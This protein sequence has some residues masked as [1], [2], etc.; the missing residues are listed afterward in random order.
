MAGD[1]AM[2]ADVVPS[3]PSIRIPSGISM[4]DVD[5]PPSVM[6]G[7]SA[8]T[9]IPS[10]V[11]RA[12]HAR[13]SPT[14]AFHE[15]VMGSTFAPASGLSA[16][17][18]SSPPPVRERS[19]SGRRAPR[20][21]LGYGQPAPRPYALQPDVRQRH[22]LGGVAFTV[23]AKDEKRKS[24]IAREAKEEEEANATANK[25][26]INRDAEFHTTN[27]LGVDEKT[28]LPVKS[29]ICGACQMAIFAEGPGATGAVA[30]SNGQY[31][32]P[33]CF[34]CQLC[35]GEIKG[36]HCVPIG[37]HIYHPGACTEKV[38][39]R[40]CRACGG[41]ILPGEEIREGHAPDVFH[42]RCFKCAC[43]T[44]P[45]SSEV[46][47]ETGADFKVWHPKLEKFEDLQGPHGYMCVRCEERDHTFFMKFLRPGRVDEEDELRTEFGEREQPR[48]CDLTKKLPPLEE[49][50]HADATHR[51]KP[52]LHVNK[53]FDIRVDPA[54]VTCLHCNDSL[55]SLQ[56]SEPAQ[57]AR[58]HRNILRH[59]DEC[60]KILHHAWV[61]LRCQ[62]VME[63]DAQEQ[64]EAAAQER[65]EKRRAEMDEK[66]R[67]RLEVEAAL[68]AEHAAREAEAAEHT[69][70][71]E[72]QRLEAEAKLAVELRK[73]KGVAEEKEHEMEDHAHELE[74]A[75]EDARRRREA[76]AA[77]AAA[78][79][80][81]E[82]A[83]HKAEA[84]AAAAELAAERERLEEEAEE[85]MHEMEE[86]LAE[87]RHRMADEAAAAIREAEEERL[88]EE[89][90]RLRAQEE[91]VLAEEEEAARVEAEEAALQTARQSVA[92]RQE[93][94]RLAE[95]LD[96][97]AQK[98][99]EMQSRA[100]AREQEWIDRHTEREDKLLAAL[101]RAPHVL[102]A[103]VLAK[104]DTHMHYEK[105]EAAMQDTLTEDMRAIFA[106]KLSGDDHT[107][108]MRC[109]VE[110][111]QARIAAVEQIGLLQESCRRAKDDLLEKYEKQAPPVGPPFELPF[112]DP[113]VQDAR[114]PPEYLINAGDYVE[115]AV[116]K[117]SYKYGTLF[118]VGSKAVVRKVLYNVPI[119]EEPGDAE[120]G[121]LEA[122]RSLSPLGRRA[123]KGERARAQQV[124]QI[125]LEREGR[126]KELMLSQKKIQ[127]E[128]AERRSSS[129]PSASG[130]NNTSRSPTSRSTTK[131]HMVKIPFEGKAASKDYTGTVRGEAEVSL[132]EVLEEAFG[133]DEPITDVY[134]KGS[135]PNAKKK[136]T[137]V[138]RAY[139]L[140][141]LPPG[142]DPRN[143]DSFN[144]FRAGSPDQYK[145]HGIFR[146]MDW[147]CG[148]GLYLDGGKM[149]KTYL[150]KHMWVR[151]CDLKLYMSARELAQAGAGS[152][153]PL[154]VPRSGGAATASPFAGATSMPA[155][156]EGQTQDQMLA[157]AL[158]RYA[159]VV[160]GGSGF[161]LKQLLAKLGA[162]AGGDGAIAGGETIDGPNANDLMKYLIQPWDI[163][164]KFL[165]GAGGSPIPG[166]ASQ[167]AT[168]SLQRT[169]EPHNP[170]IKRTTI[171]SDADVVEFAD[172]SPSGNARRSTTGSQ[173]AAASLAAAVVIDN[174]RRT[175]K[176]NVPLTL[177][178]KLTQGLKENPETVGEILKSVGMT[179]AASAATG[180]G[181]EQESAAVRGT[182][183]RPSSLVSLSHPLIVKDRVSG[184]SNT[185]APPADED[186]STDVRASLAATLKEEREIARSRMLTQQGI[187]V[188][189]VG[190]VVS[191]I[192]GVVTKRKEMTVTEAQEMMQKISLRKLASV[193]DNLSQVP[194]ADAP[195]IHRVFTSLRPVNK[196]LARMKKIADDSAAGSKV[197]T[198]NAKLSTV[199]SKRSTASASKQSVGSPASLQSSEVSKR[200]T[201][202]ETLEAVKKVSTALTALD[203]NA[204]VDTE[205][206][207]EALAVSLDQT[208]RASG[209]KS[210]DAVAVEA[211]RGSTKSQNR[212]A[213]TASAHSP[214]VVARASGARL[215][216]AAGSRAGSGVVERPPSH[217]SQA[218]SR[219]GSGV[220]ERPPSQRSHHSE[221]AS[222]SR[223]VVKGSV[224]VP[225][226][227]RRSSSPKTSVGHA[228][229]VKT[230]AVVRPSDA[231]NRQSSASREA[232]KS[233][234][235]PSRSSGQAGSVR[236][237]SGASPVEDVA[238]APST[239]P[240]G[241][242][243]A[244][245]KTR[246]PSKG[247]ASIVERASGGSKG[248]VR[249][250]ST[251]SA[252]GAVPET[253]APSTT[254][255]RAA[256]SV[257]KSV[258]IEV[259]RASGTAPEA[260]GAPV[261]E[262]SL[263]APPTAANTGGGSTWGG[264]F[265]GPMI[266]G[267]GY[268]DTSGATPAEAP[269]PVAPA[270]VAAHVAAPVPATPP[271]AP[272]PVAA[273]PPPAA[274]AGT[275]QCGLWPGYFKGPMV[276]GKGYP[277]TSG[278]VAPVA[279]A[280]VAAAPVAPVAAPVAQTPPPAPAPVS[281]PA[282]VAA[283][284]PAA[285]A[286][287]P[288]GGV[289]PGYFKG[290]MVAGK[291]YPDTS[292]A[293]A[294]V[295]AAPVAAAPVAAAPVAASQEG[296][297]SFWPT[298]FKGPAVA[299]K[300]YP[301]V[302]ASAAQA[303]RGGSGLGER[304]SGM[305]S[306]GERMSG[307]SAGDRMSGMSAGGER[308]LGSATRAEPMSAMSFAAKQSVSSHSAGGGWSATSESGDGGSEST[309]PK[310]AQQPQRRGAEGE[311]ANIR[312]SKGSHAVTVDLMAMRGSAAEATQKHSNKGA[313]SVPPSS[314]PDTRRKSVA[315]K[316]REHIKKGYSDGI[317]GAIQYTAW[318][319]EQAQGKTPIVDA[320]FW[321]GEQREV[322]T[323]AGVYDYAASK[324]WFKLSVM[325]DMTAWLNYGYFDRHDE[326]IYYEGDCQLS[327]LFTDSAV[328][329][330]FE[331]IDGCADYWARRQGQ[332]F[333][334]ARDPATGKLS[335][336]KTRMIQLLCYPGQEGA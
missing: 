95:I 72:Q 276:A 34:V 46:P 272:A 167:Q 137:N 164:E 84:A 289:W 294:P 132:E 265:K 334:V 280:P 70:D 202:A 36:N 136:S 212:G 17:S 216:S 26:E 201:M 140:S 222:P 21:P 10:E 266:A 81:A 5:V 331:N 230:S 179:T 287:A 258:S 189:A 148:D 6:Q 91:K 328:E 336:N 254:A 170:S 117:K 79:L 218:R 141:F 50:A 88:H 97:L 198:V 244:S 200:P 174:F 130:V 120:R 278:A 325:E 237:P 135:K 262:P 235:S 27:N 65:R 297:V 260:V 59:G 29:R 313:T 225:D 139:L 234:H 62:E 114:I 19:A 56:D 47:Y 317:E 240:A 288:Q 206:I 105:Q 270:P 67:L 188:E 326:K 247:K 13:S 197:S 196:D 250:T 159:D 58:D 16:Q 315:E 292:G 241:P 77:A 195:E 98:L 290:P 41:L 249:G 86:A 126:Q 149:N 246:S 111:T 275:P 166:R 25:P 69:R 152:V 233:Q 256:S 205:S 295:A 113:R 298:Y 199:N 181:K 1:S 9:T 66:D 80:E 32:H 2:Y 184:T 134:Y 296:G 277:D 308:M 245:A 259:A 204:V 100:A 322:L 175:T 221:V 116:A 229:V 128:M 327:M 183:L 236:A 158:Q 316:M 154:F 172:F 33:A 220:V 248:P 239:R 68:A 180:T 299:G 94:A 75:L 182:G 332:T 76:D 284:P 309:T 257:K 203:A 147:Y 311:V 143:P 190:S 85:R 153:H 194:F 104:Q 177:V 227:G 286:A 40:L 61:C 110:A 96:D 171:L 24:Q 161:G 103:Y 273:T 53:Q 333:M 255:A 318:E 330:T 44:V 302:R 217:R 112:E 28:Q 186:G 31:Y 49:G 185:D 305:S 214:S 38:Y 231:A 155:S 8:A 108:P 193:S 169:S 146:D 165:V 124:D 101:D 226:E 192:A 307:M 263:V 271:P 12:G 281:A 219:V 304:M 291:G 283:A 83:Q 133:I 39:E 163:D 138:Q 54:A 176:Q 310:D 261:E 23:L 102:Q 87:E 121:E 60:E 22:E 35:K 109:E 122:N 187:D 42:A 48:V 106:T 274:S 43:C 3:G 207:V 74:A 37:G 238:R 252:G 293:A 162:S 321:D 144:P 301:G 73:L 215:G 213:S 269:V 92:D 145:G 268:P 168:K 264:Y 178:R 150:T 90:D 129:R 18:S 82:R 107:S 115:L 131:K 51:R 279:A 151:K 228:S 300:G 253:R 99:E 30:A 282:P 306:A 123:T 224:V 335:V 160:Q 285:Y 242:S 119:R 191:E 324:L 267:K 45:F 127:E 125:R 7:F 329:F 303:S 78:A 320:I 142:L 208:V 118:P 243:T 209:R 157:A 57:F 52:L 20:A 319:T 55:E 210:A 232:T 223:S 14:G 71:E 11:V 93:N 156:S 312:Y 4:P 173:E 323:P 89:E 251:A 211:A 15:T 64:A 314:P 63:K